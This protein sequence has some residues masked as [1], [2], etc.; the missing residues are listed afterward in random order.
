M[1]YNSSDQTPFAFHYMPPAG[2]RVINTARYQW[3]LPH[4]PRAEA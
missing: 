1:P 4:E 2:E 3:W